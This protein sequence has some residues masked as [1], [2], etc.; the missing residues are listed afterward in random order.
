MKP[1]QKKEWVNLQPKADNKDPRNHN[2]LGN[3]IKNLKKKDNEKEMQ[4]LWRAS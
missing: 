2:M 1:K 3:L 4:D